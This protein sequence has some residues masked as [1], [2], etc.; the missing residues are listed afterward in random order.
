MFGLLV[1]NKPAGPTSHDVVTGVRRRLGRGVKVGHAGTLDPFAEGVLVVCVGA[2]TRLASYVQARPKR[3]LAL[4][5]LGATS[6]TDDP[7]GRITPAPGASGPDDST[8]REALA[9]FVGA[10]EQVP[11]AHSAVHVNGRRAYRLARTGEAVDLPPRT[12]TVHSL[13]LARYEYPHLEIDVRCGA[14]TYIRALA[15]D[16]GSALGVGAYC[17]RLTRTAVGD[18]RIEDA[19]RPQDLDPP[20]DLLPPL[21]ALSSLPRVTVTAPQAA[22]LKHG[23]CLALCGEVPPGEVAV[24]D[25]HANLLAI[26]EVRTDGKTLWPGKVFLHPSG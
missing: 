12:V 22:R 8:V 9:R 20:R 18:F 4:L 2:A 13:D 25:S 7:E 10:I 5:R 1:I 21:A 26:A 15:R 17:E 3:Y 19:L 24:I 11:P 14:G 6:S 16:I 23:N